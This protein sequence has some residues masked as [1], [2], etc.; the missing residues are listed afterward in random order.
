MKVL[1]VFLLFSIFLLNCASEKFPEKISLRIPNHENISAFNYAVK[2]KVLLELLNAEVEFYDKNENFNINR[3]EETWNTVLNNSV[4]FNNKSE[5]IAW[6]EITGFLLELTGKEKFAAELEKT[7]QFAKQQNIDV[8]KEIEK[9]VVTRNIDHLFVNLFKNT[10]TK[11]THSLGG[12]MVF[13]QETDY[14]AT[15][16]VNL[17]FKTTERRYAE[18]YIRIPD[19]AEGTLVEVK[20]VKYFAPPGAYCKIAKKWK[21]G[22]LVEIQF[23]IEKQ[24]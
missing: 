10:E 9:F 12:E 2:N 1:F 4:N 8:R 14:P 3:F 23:P 5:I 24:R 6:I 18:L 17:H 11:Y 7:E 20:K 19:W 22:D 21:D 16:K 15:G 13:I